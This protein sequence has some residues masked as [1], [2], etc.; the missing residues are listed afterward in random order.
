MKDGR[1]VEVTGPAE[2]VRDLVQAATDLGYGVES[3]EPKAVRLVD[4]HVRIEI[5]SYVLSG[6]MLRRRLQREEPE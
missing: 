1:P 5:E 3:I 2:W 4:K 6:A